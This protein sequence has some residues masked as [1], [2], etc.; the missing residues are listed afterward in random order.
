M[1]LGWIYFRP[2]LLN[3]EDHG[4]SNFEAQSRGFGTRCL[5]FM[6]A[7]PQT[8]QDS[9]PTADQP[10]RVGVITYRTSTEGFYAF[11]LSP[12]PERAWRGEQLPLFR[13]L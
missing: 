11:M 10:F 2:R 5:R 1:I 4:D 6:P 3:N 7:L 9:L 13:D 8:M 12:F